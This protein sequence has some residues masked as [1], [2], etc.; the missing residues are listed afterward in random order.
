MQ[1]QLSLGEYIRRLRKR[2]ECSLQSVAEKAGIS[3]SHLSRI[4]NDSTLPN[5]NTVALI[6]GALNGD[7]K[8]MLEM[9]DCLPRAILDRIVAHEEIGGPASLRRTAGSEEAAAAG[10][11]ADRHLINLAVASGADDAEANELAK[12]VGQLM[13]LTPTQRRAVSR[14]IK[15]LYRERDESKG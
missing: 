14:L 7:L 11:D 15:S 13:R 2:E 3:Y 10:G 9:A 12:A 5:P 6:A 4:E 1:D 8:L